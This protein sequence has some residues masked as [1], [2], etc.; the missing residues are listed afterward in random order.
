M[1]L[2]LSGGCE[3][4]GIIGISYDDKHTAKM[5]PPKKLGGEAANGAKNDAQRASFAKKDAADSRGVGSNSK[6]DGKTQN[7]REPGLVFAF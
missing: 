4:E 5:A 7:G 6:T 1:R 3:A 2:T